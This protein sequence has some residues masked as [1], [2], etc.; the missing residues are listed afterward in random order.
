MHKLMLR[1][2]CYEF[3][4]QYIILEKLRFKES[5]SY[6]ECQANEIDLGL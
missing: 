5:S 3:T 4:D 1:V 2:N 6:Q